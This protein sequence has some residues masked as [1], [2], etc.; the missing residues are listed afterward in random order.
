MSHGALSHVA[1]LT[2]VS[3]EELAIIRLLA[4]SAHAFMG[5]SRLDSPWP[6]YLEAM[7]LRRVAFPDF[8]EPWLPSPADRPPP[9][10][11]SNLS[12][13]NLKKPAATAAASACYQVRKLVQKL[14]NTVTSPN[15][16]LSNSD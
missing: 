14:Y 2:A 13:I 16:E 9:E 11:N 5:K 15:K 12:E 7:L 4:T 1:S 8:C 10:A 6:G 3:R